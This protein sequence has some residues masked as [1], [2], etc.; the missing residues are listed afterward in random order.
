MELYLIRHGQSTNNRGDARVPDPPLTEIG[1]Q[2]ADR[3]GR[4]LK[5]L[6]ITRLYCSA[7]LRAVQTAAF[8]S[9]HLELAP[10]VFVGIHE[11]GGIWE[12]R[13]DGGITQLPGMTRSQLR[14][15]CSSVV[16]PNDAT[17]EGW[18]FP[19]CD[20]DEQ[21]PLLD[22]ARILRLVNRN[23]LEFVAHLDQ[24]HLGEDEKIGAI[25]HGGSGSI[26]LGTLLESPQAKKSLNRFP[27]NN[28]GISKIRRTRDDTQ[29]L[30]LNRTRHLFGEG[31][32]NPDGNS[33][34]LT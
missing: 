1:K 29:F 3:A 19:E 33:P 23:C 14:E 4:A 5:D 31:A 9:K 13:V 2:Q 20:S 10:H 26:M 12:D 21:A 8:V 34:L 17:D 11:W 15:V 22:D 27:H 32:S 28:T 24:H 18:W 6:G 7:M 25:T 16:L 30:Y